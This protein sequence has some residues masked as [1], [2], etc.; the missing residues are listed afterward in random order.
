MP[1]EKELPKYITWGDGTKVEINYETDRERVLRE[2]KEAIGRKGEERPA[3]KPKDK[4]N[5]PSI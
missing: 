1:K 3:H 4:P 5:R 2:V